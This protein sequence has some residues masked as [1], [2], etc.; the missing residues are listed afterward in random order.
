[1]CAG[2]LRSIEKTLG[3]GGPRVHE[4][5]VES[6]RSIPTTTNEVD[7]LRV[8]DLANISSRHVSKGAGCCCQYWL[9]TAP[10]ACENTGSDPGSVGVQEN[11]LRTEVY[12]PIDKW[13]QVHKEFTVGLLDFCAIMIPT[14]CQLHL[15]V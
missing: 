15:L 1:M 4:R 11:Q 2:L 8:A 10:T 5:E 13:L 6:G 14:V 3:S 12:A 7:S 9:T